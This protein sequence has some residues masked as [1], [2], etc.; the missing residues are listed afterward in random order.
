MRRALGKGLSQ[1]IGEQAETAAQ[2]A[3]IEAIIPNKRQPRTHFNEEALAE[4]AESVKLHG[5]LQPLVVRAIGEGRYELIAGERRLRAAKLAG[6]S[7]VPIVVRSAGDQGSLE[8]ALIENVQR[9]DISALEAAKAYRKLMD[10]F[11]LTQEQVASKVGK[12]RVA[13]ANTVRLLKLPKKILEGLETGAISEGHAR[14]LL[15]VEDEA[16][17]LA[18]FDRILKGGLTV[19]D[20]ERAAQATEKARSKKAKAAK[21]QPTLDPEWAELESGMSVYFGSP[22]KLQRGEVGGKIVID[23]YSDDDLGRILDVLGI[24]L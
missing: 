16:L 17:Q 15:G 6:L 10:E 22:V 21:S 8:L 1:L 12:S 7:N 20:V 4:L 18:L 9:E 13:I 3:P 5:I 19:R 2:E 23:F 24:H 14:A 11:S